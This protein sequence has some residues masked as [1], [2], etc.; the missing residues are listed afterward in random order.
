MNYLEYCCEKNTSTKS[1]FKRHLESHHPEL[2]E[3]EKQTILKSKFKRKIREQNRTKKECKNCN[4]VYVNNHTCQKECIN[5]NK[6]YVKNNHV[7]KIQI[8]T[9]T[10]LELANKIQDDTIK[11]Q[12]LDIIPVNNTQNIINIQTNDINTNTNISNIYNGPVNIIIQLRNIGDENLTNLNIQEVLKKSYDIIDRNK[13]Y[14]SVGAGELGILTILGD[15]H[16]NDKYPENKNIRIAP[17]DDKLLLYN[18]NKWEKHGRKE[19]ANQIRKLLANLYLICKLNNNK[20]QK[21]L[22]TCMNASLDV[23]EEDS[24]SYDFM[25]SLR[26]KFDPENDIPTIKDDEFLNERYNPKNEA[27]EDTNSSNDTDPFEVINKPIQSIKD[28]PKSITDIPKSIKEIPKSI[29]EISKSIKDIHK[30]LQP[31]KEVIKMKKH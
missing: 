30:T 23:L 11:K 16:C 24:G 10:I 12:L 1:N 9:S 17:E 15:I 13:Q 18:N 5:C 8:D 21:E 20:H 27:D 7:C 6:F 4:K 14:D 26:N 25:D 29:K 3:H 22:E 19:I 2:N 28:I 31:T